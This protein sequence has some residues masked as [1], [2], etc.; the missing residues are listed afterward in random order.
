MATSDENGVVF[1]EETDAISPFA[2]L[3]NGLQTGTSGAI[4]VVKGSISDLEE[5]LGVEG[6]RI[7]ALEALFPAP[8]SYT[9]TI[10]GSVTNPTNYT[11]SG[12]YVQIGKLCLAMFNITAGASF[13]AGSGTYTISLPVS[14][15]VFAVTAGSARIYDA[16]TG[17]AHLGVRPALVGANTLGIQY[18]A[19]HGGSLSTVGAAG[20]WTW[21]SGDIIDG[22]LIYEAD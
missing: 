15:R 8:A 1:L 21:A 7:T 6:G 13:T 10:T 5:D 22:F 11:A 12:R 9:P 20:P 17:N 19:T 16:S 14:A 4:D 18:T 2:P 3:I